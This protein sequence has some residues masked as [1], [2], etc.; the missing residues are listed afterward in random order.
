MALRLKVRLTDE[1]SGLSF[2]RS[3]GLRLTLEEKVEINRS[4]ESSS[5][6]KKL[7]KFFSKL[8][9]KST[10]QILSAYRPRL[11]GAVHNPLFDLWLTLLMPESISLMRRCQNVD[12]QKYFVA[13]PSKK[14]FCSSTCRN[15]HWNR[16]RRIASGHGKS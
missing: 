11:L 10:K 13:W 8:P 15:R 5:D 2:L 16:P 6:Q 12:C 1:K 14:Q 4:Y 7:E 9:A 3:V